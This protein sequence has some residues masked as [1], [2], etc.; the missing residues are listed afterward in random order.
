VS[1]TTVAAGSLNTID[2]DTSGLVTATAATT[3]TGTAT[4]IVTAIGSTGISTTTTY[5][6]TVSDTTVAAG[7]LN[8]IDTDTT[9]LVDATAA[10]TITGTATDIVTAIG[11]TGISTTTT[12]AATVS[13]TTATFEQIVAIDADTTGTVSITSLIDVSIADTSG[14]LSPT[15]ADVDASVT[16]SN[17]DT[18]NIVA[19]AT[20][21]VGTA[22]LASS[23]TL[24]FGG[25][26][27]LAYQVASASSVT[28]G[29][30]MLI[31]GTWTGGVFTVDSVAGADTL[32]LFDSDPNGTAATSSVVLLGVAPSGFTTAP[33]GFTIN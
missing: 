4:E 9:G 25:T 27:S 33:D 21:N 19:A 17:T 28:D 30:F 23:D 26:Q 29:E 12:Y 14:V 18:F 15:Y 10:T 2:T 7:S 5:A 24:S 11:S 1:D 32:V 8:T 6:A 16:L 22:G 13:G 31:Q 20:L 3:I